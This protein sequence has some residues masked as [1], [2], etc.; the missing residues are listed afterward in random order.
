M[1]LLCQ[2]PLADSLC[3][4]YDPTEP[5]FLTQVEFATRLHSHRQA[6]DPRSYT[7]PD[8]TNPVNIKSHSIFWLI[9]STNFQHRTRK[10]AVLSALSNAEFFNKFLELWRRKKAWLQKGLEPRSFRSEVWS[11]TTW[12]T[13]P[14][15]HTMS[16]IFSS[17]PHW[18]IFKW[19][20]F[21]PLWDRNIGSLTL[22]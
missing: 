13:S 8:S 3:L 15:H 7:P 14:I 10:F 9:G 4:F 12:P 16:S 18:K 11:S 6:L 1:Q 17:F 21:L 5:F 22:S 2:F 19:K 20:I